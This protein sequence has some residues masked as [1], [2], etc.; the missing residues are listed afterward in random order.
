MAKK[1]TSNQEV[2][3]AL[4]LLNTA[5]SEEKQRI[6]DAGAASMKKQD[7][8]T[9][10]AVLDFADK[11]DDFRSDV[12]ALVEKW[13]ELLQIRED[14]TPAVQQIVTGEGRLFS[15]KPRRIT[16]GFSR[17]IN[18]PLAHKTIF[19]VSFDDGT[20]LMESK[21]EKTLLKAIEKIGVEQVFGLNLS[22]SGEPLVSKTQSRKYPSASKKVGE[23]YVLTHSN[24]A[25]KVKQL[26]QI[27][28]LLSVNAKIQVQEA[29]SPNMKY[30][31]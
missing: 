1:D 7:S 6:Y 12:E 31:E 2:S 18:H 11:L 16:T 17:K 4:D 8:K 23:Y 3:V 13:N 21:A 27:M 14:A 29:Q 26:K 28:K 22:L 20:R 9:A 15:A 25:A 24:T 30:G 5:L 19:S 10:R